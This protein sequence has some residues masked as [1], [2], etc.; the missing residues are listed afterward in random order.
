MLFELQQ[1]FLLAL[2]HVSM[3]KLL[4]R[5]RSHCSCTKTEEKISVFVKVFTLI[6]RITPQKRM[7]LKTLSKVDIHRSGG[8]ENAF[9][10]CER[11]KTEVF[12][13]APMLNN[14]FHKNGAM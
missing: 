4:Q 6:S 5:P 8:F 2:H 11:I 3:H 9:D 14:E 12:E 13:N 7:F 10:Q 1:I